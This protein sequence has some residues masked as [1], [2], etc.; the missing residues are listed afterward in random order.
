MINNINLFPQ[1]S[2]FIKKMAESV[3]ADTTVK[4]MQRAERVQFNIL[5]EM[6]SIEHEAKLRQKVSI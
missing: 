4:H 3:A 2:T 5:N 1:F 6:Y